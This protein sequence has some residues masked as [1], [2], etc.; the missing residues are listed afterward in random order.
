MGGGGIA[1]GPGGQGGPGS[2]ILTVKF[3][4]VNGNTANGGPIA[5]AGG[6]ANGGTATITASQVAGNTA[7][8]AAGGGILNHGVMTIT[9]SKVTGNTAPADSAG[10]QGMGGGIANINLGPVF[11]HLQRRHLDR[12]LQPDQPQHR[13]RARRRRLRGHHHQQWPGPRAAR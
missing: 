7:P 11:R 6:I 8:G 3:S 9:G 13:V 2:S 10:D 4:Q 1:S 12:H 5:S